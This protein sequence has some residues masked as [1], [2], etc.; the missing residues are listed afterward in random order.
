V[1]KS[2]LGFLLFC[3]CTCCSLQGF[4]DDSQ[5]VGREYQLKT[6][7]LFHFA[8]LAEWPTASPVTICLQ[9][10]S[11]IHTYLPILDG[12]AIHNTEVQVKMGFPIVVAECRI[13]FMSDL[14]VLSPSLLEQAY[15]QHVL[16]VSDATGFA[17]K[18]GMIEFALRDNKLKLVVNLQ[19]VKQAGL[20]LSS[21]LLRMAEIL[22]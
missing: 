20:K 22:E 17:A 14:H 16:I 3:A 2:V 7:Y 11:P 12:Q 21:K 10:N 5:S 9:G 19:S 6:V 15:K 4:A 13:I 18:G 8:E 1:P